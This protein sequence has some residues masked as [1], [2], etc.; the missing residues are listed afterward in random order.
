ML[1]FTI[2]IISMLFSF[3]VLLDQVVWSGAYQLHVYDAIRLE[4]PPGTFSVPLVCLSR[5][6][7]IKI[8]TDMAL[9]EER[10]I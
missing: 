8:M 9:V 7:V 2:L 4:F 1:F 10:W 6:T 5:N 3:N